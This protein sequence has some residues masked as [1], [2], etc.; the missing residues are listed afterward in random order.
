MT[1]E[2]TLEKEKKNNTVETKDCCMNES[3]IEMNVVL[4]KAN[5][6][7]VSPSEDGETATDTWRLLQSWSHHEF[8]TSLAFVMCSTDLLDGLC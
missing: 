4:E 3:I 2:I 1:E 5:V 7:F 8:M 6:C